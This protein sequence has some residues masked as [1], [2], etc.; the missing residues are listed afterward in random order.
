[1]ISAI[2][3]AVGARSA[4]QACVRSH[5][6]LGRCSSAQCAR[7][8][9]PPPI[10]W[11]DVG[12]KRARSPEQGPVSKKVGAGTASLTLGA[13][14]PSPLAVVWLRQPPRLRRPPPESPQQSWPPRCTQHM[15]RAHG[16]R[17]MSL[18]PDFWGASSWLSSDV[19]HLS[20]QVRCIAQS[21]FRNE[22]AP[23]L[24]MQPGVC[25]TRAT[26]ARHRPI[27]ATFGPTR[28]VWPGFGQLWA[29]SAKFG[30][31]STKF[32]PISIKVDQT[33]S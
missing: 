19:V 25:R 15:C 33:W 16:A 31:S 29:S 4:G 21:A 7:S 13:A 28:P 18:R 22:A 20:F 10:F 12:G 3:R 32:D 2:S 11:L 23:I 5:W 26:S 9:A 1:M 8:C 6:H 17:C 27:S 14:L 30:L 24:G